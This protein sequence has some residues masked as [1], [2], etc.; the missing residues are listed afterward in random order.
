MNCNMF[1]STFWA[2]RGPERFLKE[3]QVK[4]RKE[5]IMC[6]YK[7]YQELGRYSYFS[8]FQDRKQKQSIGTEVM[9]ASLF[10]REEF[11]NLSAIFYRV[12]AALYSLLKSSK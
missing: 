5:F 1:Y 2:V 12:P 10:F 8:P 3:T 7:W 6:L 11:R 4:F 9:G